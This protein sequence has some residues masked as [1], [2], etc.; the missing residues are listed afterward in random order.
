MNIKIIFTSIVFFVSMLIAVESL[1]V[2]IAF[3]TTKRGNTNLPRDKI[4]S[5][6][7]Q[8]IDLNNV[9]AMKIQVIFDE[10]NS[11]EHI[12]VFKLS[13]KYLEAAIDKINIDSNF[14]FISL[15][16]NYK[17]SPYDIAQ[18][19]PE[20]ANASCPDPTIRFI[21]FA[22]FEEGKEI[23][24]QRL[25]NSVADTA[26]AHNLKTVRLLL[27][28]ATA[29]NY[30]SYMTCPNLIGNYAS[31]HG[32]EDGKLMTYDGYII[33]SDISSILTEKFKFKVT[34]IWAA[35]LVFAS[36]MA[37][38]MIEDAETQKFIAGITK[39]PIDVGT[40]IAAS[41]MIRIIS[42]ANIK[43]ADAFGFY[44]K[45]YNKDPIKNKWGINIDGFGSD[46]F[47]HESE[48]SQGVAAKS[49]SNSAWGETAAVA[50]AT[51][52]TIVIG[53]YAANQM[54]HI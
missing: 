48:I 18:R 49:T 33:P 12:L 5:M 30:L 29:Q 42:D 2:D 3:W 4:V 15:E 32:F 26:V 31:T 25:A 50:G 51:A 13:N 46:Y 35:C 17:L 34:T 10:Q 14:N 38:A 19:I 1:A 16:R 28:D 36:P 44:W 27:K 21:V 11:P 20:L 54:N 41:T 37:A 43:I 39:V 40:Q 6:V 45:Q 52:S 22:P 9:A 24:E 23:S 8:T 47:A 7:K 53:T